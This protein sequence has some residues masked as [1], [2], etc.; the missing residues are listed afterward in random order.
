MGNF[1]NMRCFDA[2][3]LKNIFFA[4]SQGFR[5]LPKLLRFPWR[6]S[7]HQP[8]EVSF[9]AFLA[10]WQNVHIHSA[11]LG[12]SVICLIF[13][14]CD[15]QGKY[16]LS[17]CSCFQ[18]RGQCQKAQEFFSKLFASAFATVV[19]VSFCCFAFSLQWG[20]YASQSLQISA[21]SKRGRQLVGK[22][23]I[24]IAYTVFEC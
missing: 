18:V 10:S 1:G 7:A 6:R 24:V 15:C 19:H 21:W 8:T 17:G 12:L 23:R 13:C 3:Q 2:R 11:Y 20:W 14:L 4:P 9:A 16:K 5:T 22:P